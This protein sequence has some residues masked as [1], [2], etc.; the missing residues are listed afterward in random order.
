MIQPYQIVL[1]IWEGNPDIDVPTLCENGVVGLIVR[2]NDMNGG[3]HLDAQFARN[4][5]L[6]LQFPVQTLYFVYNP[7][8]SGRANYDW[9]IAHLPAD[10]GRRRLMID[11]EVKY[12]DYAPATYAK[13]V[14]AFRALVNSICPE[15]IYTGYGSLPLLDEWP[16]T[17][18]YWWAA[19]P[20]MLTACTSWAEYKKALSVV[21]MSAFTK[22]SPG[23]ARLWQCTGDGV[24]LEGFG[25]HAVDVNVFPG[26]LEQLAAWLGCTLAPEPPEPPEQPEEVNMW[27]D[28]ALGLVT[29]TADWTN[30]NFDF[31]VG[32]TGKGYETPNPSLKA[33]EAKATL[34][35][36][37]FL[38]LYKFSMAYYTGQ[39]YP[40]QPERWPSYA[41]DF[42]LQM[43]VRAI[44]NR[45]VKAVVL[46]VLDPN[47]HTGKPGSKAWVSFASRE[48]AKKAAAWLKD[49]KPG[50]PLILSTSQPF[51]EEYAP[52][53]L[54]WVHQYDSCVDQLAKLDSS[55]P[56]AAEK[57]AYLGA[58]DGWEFWR[59]AP[60]LMLFDGNRKACWDYLDFKP[61]P[62]VVKKLARAVGGMNIRSGPGTGFK[63]LG[64]LKA[65]ETIEIL[66]TAETKS[67]GLVYVWGKH[68]RGWTA[69]SQVKRFMELL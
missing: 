65:G 22:Y 7:W 62:V 31:I 43:L 14:A 17:C 30:P 60:S 20:F 3:H 8:V 48:F 12:K 11:V 27:K 42:P 24:R 35:G 50:V 52:D 53:M 59:Y 66:E 16:K 45:D 32:V 1:D 9:L 55:Y 6:A 19:Y 46:E 64:M 58:A 57:P 29:E 63:S 69:L 25:N 10:Y 67:N 13:E 26:T 39:Q 5:A 2:L 61:A 28:N 51:M 68:A 54:N 34:E 56:A 41:M 37:P 40:M 33:I 36:K 49:N 47:D 15:T 44:Q 18:D 21:S 38:E 4:W 23:P